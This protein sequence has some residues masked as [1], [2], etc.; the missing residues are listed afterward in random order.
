MEWEHLILTDR[1]S[2]ADEK[3]LIKRIL[4]TEL[5]QILISSKF[6][7]RADPTAITSRSDFGTKTTSWS[8]SF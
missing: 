1:I 3:A 2:L 6:T 5:P 8:T 7:K 4:R